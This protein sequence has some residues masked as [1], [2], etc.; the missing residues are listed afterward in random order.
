MLILHLWI[1]RNWVH[2]Q[3]ELDN[4]LDLVKFLESPKGKKG[5]LILSDPAF[6]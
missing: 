3:I 2:D 1:K 5:F 4:V 6:I